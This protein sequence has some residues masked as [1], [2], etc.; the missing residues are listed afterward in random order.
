M[1]SAHTSTGS[2]EPQ[3]EKKMKFDNWLAA[4]FV[5]C[6]L[7]ACGGG[8]YQGEPPPFTTVKQVSE[9][10]WEAP[11]PFNRSVYDQIVG[12]DDAGY[13][14]VITEGGQVLYDKTLPEFGYQAGILADGT[15]IRQVS[16]FA[17][18]SDFLPSKEYLF[19]G[20]QMFPLTFHAVR[21]GQSRHIVAMDLAESAGADWLII[22]AAEVTPYTYNGEQSPEDGSQRSYWAAINRYTGEMI[23][24][25]Y[26]D[27]PPLDMSASTGY[28]RSLGLASVTTRRLSVRFAQVSR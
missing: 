28:K 4:L 7:T 9:I 12:T 19:V 18:V 13:R 24:Y 5:A 21:A 14:V 1:V 15:R 17:S 6:V 3:Q 26:Y 2:I 11:T 25:G 22:Y 27:E 10:Y 23:E 16:E 8:D 20:N